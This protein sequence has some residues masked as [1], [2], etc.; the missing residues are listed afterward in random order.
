LVL[1]LQLKEK[2]EYLQSVA[3][4]EEGEGIVLELLIGVGFANFFLKQA[5]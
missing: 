2:F 4:V 1:L 5:V 3:I